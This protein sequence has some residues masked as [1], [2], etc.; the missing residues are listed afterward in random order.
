MLAAAVA[1][2]ITAEQ[3][4]LL[5]LQILPVPVFV[6]VGGGTTSTAASAV[7]QLL[8]SPRRGGG[9]CGGSAPEQPNAEL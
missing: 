2:A 3:S 4:P 1:T 9:G 7:E 6:D 5:L 8:S